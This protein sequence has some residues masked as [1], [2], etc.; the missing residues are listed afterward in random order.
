MKKIFDWLSTFSDLFK[1]LLVKNK[2]Q[3]L[4]Y[5]NKR[6]IVPL[7][8]INSKVFRL[9]V[10]F[11]LSALVN[12]SLWLV[13]ILFK[14]NDEWVVV[15]NMMQLIF[16][17]ITSVIGIW[18]ILVLIY[19]YSLYL[20]SRSKVFHIAQLHPQDEQ[21][22]AILS[23]FPEK[24]N[25][26]LKNQ[27][28]FKTE[29]DFNH[30]HFNAQILSINANKNVAKSQQK[31][32]EIVELEKDIIRLIK[33]RQQISATSLSNFYVILFWLVIFV[34][35]VVLSLCFSYTLQLYADKNRII[36]ALVNGSF[37]DIVTIFSTVAFVKLTL[38]VREIKNTKN[39]TL[40]QWDAKLNDALR[41]LNSHK[42]E[43]DQILEVILNISWI[44]DS[45]FIK[46]YKHESIQTKYEI[47]KLLIQINQNIND[48]F[49]Y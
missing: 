45:K 42:I 30:L 48:I 49:N 17:I 38:S 29:K 10:L 40:S 13:L 26:T 22:Q 16:I 44:T 8:K 18:F 32:H 41:I 3:L 39:N 5:Y 28:E 9:F 37:W 23:Y 15:T 25:K 43:S 33:T 35:L 46:I 19:S 7:E 34:C 1:M 14:P 47:S 2:Q 27:I 11:F 36:D 4:K 31:L 6:K 20:L 24:N 12:F 21:I